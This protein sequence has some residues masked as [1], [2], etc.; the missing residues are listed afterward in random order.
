MIFYEETFL[1]D[2]IIKPFDFLYHLEYYVIYPWIRNENELIRILEDKTG[3]VYKVSITQQVDNIL[4][5]LSLLVKA[6]SEEIITKEDIVWI[7]QK[8]SWCLGCMEDVNEF[9][10]MV[11]EDPV[12]TVAMQNKF[13]RRDKSTPTLFEG[14]M[15]VVFSQNAQ[16]SRI[17]SMAYNFCSLFGKK[18]ELPEGTFY[19][20]PTPNRISELSIEEIKKSKVGYRA[21]VIKEIATFF[22]NYHD[23]L[24]QID[25][26]NDDEI[27][28][29]LMNIKGVG[30]Y[31]VNLV[32]HVALRRLNKVHI[33]SFVKEIINTFYM[34][35]ENMSDEE[36]ARFCEKRWGKNAGWVISILTTDTD[37]WAKKLGVKLNI[38]SGANI[39]NNKLN[40]EIKSI[41]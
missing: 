19:S 18:I 4:D 23:A 39:K 27:K 20:F 29:Y 25:Y 17:Y 28:K 38:R 11:N 36:I 37:I 10:I 31:T 9:S 40:N 14:M 41:S 1:I 6:R 26:W 35:I 33:D 22:T 30:P 32:M 13:G 3:K 16:F 12:L 34:N 8:I 5:K 24:E 2:E 7:K 21:K 15:N